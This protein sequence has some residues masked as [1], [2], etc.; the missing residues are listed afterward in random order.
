MKVA[1]RAASTPASTDMDMSR[2]ADADDGDPERAAAI[3]L[4]KLLPPLLAV[5]VILSTVA[6][7]TTTLSRLVLNP[8]LHMARRIHSNVCG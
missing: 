1:Y 4:D 6:A 5:R 7:P 2:V 3:T 8:L